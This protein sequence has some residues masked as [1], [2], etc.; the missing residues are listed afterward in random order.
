[1]LEK[2]EIGMWVGGVLG[3]WSGGAPASSHN[4][5]LMV[6]REK[7]VPR[8]RSLGTHPLDSETDAKARS[9]SRNI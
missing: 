8:G 3:A 9:P 7:L 4:A 1:M 5:L 2:S 6:V